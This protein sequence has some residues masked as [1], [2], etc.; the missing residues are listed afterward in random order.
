MSSIGASIQA[1]TRMIEDLA[2]R[3]DRLARVEGNQRLR[4]AVVA[5]ANVA[6]GERIE[7]ELWNLG[8]DAE[9]TTYN[10]SDAKGQTT[11]AEMEPDVLAV[12]VESEAS[13]AVLA[14]VEDARAAATPTFV[15]VEPD[16]KR[17]P[18][19]EAFLKRHVFGGDTAIEWKLLVSTDGFEQELARDVASWLIGK[20]RTLSAQFKSSRTPDR[21]SARTVEAATRIQSFAR[22]PLKQGTALDLLFNDVEAWFKALG[23]HWEG[24]KR[25]SDRHVEFIVQMP[26]RRR[27]DRVLIRVVSGEATMADVAALSEVVSETGCDEGWVVCASRISPAARDSADRASNLECFTVDELIDQDANFDAYLDWLDEEVTL[28]KIDSM[29]VHLDSTKREPGMD[30]V[31]SVYDDENGGTEAYLSRW[32]ADPSKEHISVLGEF[33]TGKTWLT[34]HYAWVLAQRYREAKAAGTTRP[35][36]PLIVP[37]R[38]YAKAV[39]VESLFSE[40]LFRKHD[41][42]IKS[43]RVF[44]ELNRLGKFLLIFDGFDE[45]AARV[46]RQSMIDNFWQLASVVVPGSK[47]IL[48]CR[49]EHFPNEGEGR[50]LLGAKLE[51]SLGIHNETPPQFEVL[52]LLTLSDAKIRQLLE[53][54]SDAA[55]ASLILENQDLLELARRP[56]MSEL[57]LDALP[58]IEEGRDLSLTRIYM[59]AIR[60]KMTRDIKDE[61]TFTSLADKMFFLCE[62]SWDMF[63]SNR[64][65]V[66]YKEFP[67]TI[68]KCFGDRIGDRGDLD[69]WR[70]D[71]L[72]QTIL[73]RDADGDY[74]PAHRS[75][76]EFFAAYRAMAHLGILHPDYLEMIDMASPEGHQKFGWDEYFLSDREGD[77]ST[78]GFHRSDVQSLITAIGSAMWTPAMAQMMREMVDETVVLPDFVVDTLGE[79]AGT[80]A[81]DILGLAD[82]LARL[83]I[84]ADKNVFAGR[85][86]D[87]VTFAGAALD[88]GSDS[89]LN[90]SGA[91]LRGVN[92]SRSDLENVNMR[93]ADLSSADFTGVRFF[94]G[95][96][97]APRQMEWPRKDRLVS[98]DINGRP[99]LFAVTS[100]SEISEIKGSV[101]FDGID[102]AMLHARSTDVAIFLER[103][104]RSREKD[105]ALHVI[106]IGDG[107]TRCRIDSTPAM[108]FATTGDGSFI[109]V[110]RSANTGENAEENPYK[111]T[112]LEV[113][114]SADGQKA[115]EQDLGP[116]A[117][118]MDLHPYGDGGEFSVLM[119]DWSLERWSVE[120]GRLVRVATSDLGPVVEGNGILTE[121]ELILTR[122]QSRGVIGVG[123]VKVHSDH[124]NELLIIELAVPHRYIFVPENVRT[125]CVSGDVVVTW[126]S[127]L[128]EIRR[129]FGDAAGGRGDLLGS[130]DTEFVTAVALSP[131][132]S[133]IA[134]ATGDCSLRVFDVT[135]TQQGRVS[136]SEFY[137][138]AQFVGATGLNDQQK[139]E[140]LERGAIV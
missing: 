116:I 82:N 77:M 106:Q 135:G 33:G 137:K 46:D 49:S 109:I 118:V 117:G 36:L 86:M 31:Y 93:G 25:E 91:S 56:I 58:E 80:P 104:N 51:S 70:Y 22:E 13:A 95:E 15:L 39:S 131:D 57:I 101:E 62:L 108:A 140:L 20:Y 11:L 122:G 30:G 60:R 38:D 50:E 79:L 78:G 63:V 111:L 71:M 24:H 85:R 17:P 4:V 105:A 136:I 9:V 115:L 103:A 37:L 6:D 110:A 120:E 126:D 21:Q 53:Y 124:T 134:V 14:C 54:R 123:H 41:I 16:D 45:M 127:G 74:R 138:D 69:H 88:Y 84:L 27:Y 68:M 23:F 112:V 12:I 94:P 98:A 125:Y 100:S 66:N 47:A 8:F 132:S 26:V 44:D 83:V 92:F 61:R 76:L 42:G 48:T 113:Y 3:T 67:E 1:V 2:M 40:F 99:R 7:L 65:S 87:G 52:E 81:E 29:Y 102:V 64:L 5:D 28:R 75:F 90:L 130:V 73:I 133:R 34:L 55:T 72:G 121:P 139:K 119:L 32:L 59:Y 18:T 114:K 35:R 107:S 19:L 97:F 43:Y 129:A 128:L 96:P 89:G 10:F